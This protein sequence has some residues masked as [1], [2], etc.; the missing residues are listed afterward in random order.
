V[1]TTGT[2]TTTTSVGALKGSG[3]FPDATAPSAPVSS[4]GHNYQYVQSQQQVTTLNQ[5]KVPL[6]Y[7]PVPGFFQPAPANGA[8]LGVGTPIYV[9]TS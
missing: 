7:Q 4:N 8:G 9:Q 3:Y 6:F 1:A 5:Q 2:P